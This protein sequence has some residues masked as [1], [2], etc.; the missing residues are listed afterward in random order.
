MVLLGLQAAPYQQRPC[1]LRPPTGLFLVSRPCNP[2]AQR[3][4]LHSLPLSLSPSLAGRP[5]LTDSWVS[6]L[7]FTFSRIE[8]QHLSFILARHLPYLCAGT[9]FS[10]QDR[11]PEKLPHSGCWRTQKTRGKEGEMVAGKTEGQREGR[12][13]HYF[14][15]T[16][17][18][19]YT[20]QSELTELKTINDLIFLQ[21][22][23][24]LCPVRP[25]WHLQT[26]PEL[27]GEQPSCM[28]SFRFQ[29]WQ[30][31]VSPPNSIPFPK[32][33]VNNRKGILK[34]QTTRMERTG[35]QTTM[36]VGRWIFF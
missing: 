10:G 35:K 2:C 1:R 4:I 26:S 30:I 14:L 9:F 15:N 6:P 34:S 23:L 3:P 17:C 5:S 27:S 11:L 7:S 13:G 8:L 36:M 22:L 19:Q 24:H 32:A 18:N 21:Q 12:R 20:G 31:W 16:K 29:R 33:P 25:L 28:N